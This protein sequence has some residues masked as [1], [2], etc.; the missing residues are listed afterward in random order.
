[1][2]DRDLASRIHV[3]NAA[4]CVAKLSLRRGVNRDSVGRGR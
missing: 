4:D 3:R 2:A 1:L